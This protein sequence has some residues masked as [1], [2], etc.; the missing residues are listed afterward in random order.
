MTRYVKR[1][2]EV[3]DL[4]SFGVITRYPEELNK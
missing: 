4:I 1:I 2:N 3:A